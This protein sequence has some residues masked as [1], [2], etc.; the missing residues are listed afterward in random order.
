MWKFNKIQGSVLAD[1]YKKGWEL[2][3]LRF[4]LCSFQN[5]K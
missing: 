1:S 5:E 3:V 2:A 4:E